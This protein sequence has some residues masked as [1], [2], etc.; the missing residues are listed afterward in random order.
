VCAL[1]VPLASRLIIYHLSSLLYRAVIIIFT[2]V[3]PWSTG[4]KNEVQSR[5]SRLTSALIDAARASF[6]FFL[7]GNVD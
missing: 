2:A 6:L 5:T 1:W 4:I 3:N 7:V